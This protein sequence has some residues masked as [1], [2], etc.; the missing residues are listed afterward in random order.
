MSPPPVIV[1]RAVLVAAA[2]AAWFWSQGLIGRR[3]PPRGRI[4]DALHE[5]TA[6][7]NLWLRNN[8]RWANAVLVS[9]SGFIDLMG[10]GVIGWAVFGPSFGP[11]VGLLVLF[12]LRQSSQAVVSLPAPAGM[13]W[14]KPPIPSLLVTYGVATDLFFSGHT[15]IAVFAACEAARVGIPWLTATVATV[16]ALEATTVIVLRAHYTMDVFAAIFVALFSSAAGAAIAPWFDGGLAR[17]I[18]FLGSNPV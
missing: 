5:A 1:A 8:R 9:T 6:P 2:L 17:L 13:I 16:A 15:G 4:D 3:T 7:L 11:F 18:A 10:L 12:V 14:H